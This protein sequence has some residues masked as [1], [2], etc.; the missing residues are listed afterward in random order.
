MRDAA[1]DAEMTGRQQPAS[2][3]AVVPNPLDRRAAV[4]ADAHARAEMIRQAAQ[5]ISTAGARLC[6]LLAEAHD[7]R[8]WEILDYSGFRGYLAGEFGISRAHGY[9]L[10]DQARV[11]RD[12][13][14]AAEVPPEQIALAERASRRIANQLAKISAEVR[15][16]VAGTPP[17]SRPEIVARVVSKMAVSPA[18]DTAGDGRDAERAARALIR[19]EGND[20][21]PEGSLPEQLASAIAQ[22]LSANA[23]AV[24][25]WADYLGAAST[26]LRRRSGT[27]AAARRGRRASH[28]RSLPTSSAGGASTASS[29]QLELWP[30]EL[31]DAKEGQ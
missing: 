12:L 30:G 26:A 28:Q 4:P 11:V 29:D 6:L 10:L 14:H 19:L 3:M 8:D 31:L 27:N 5:E 21:F 16:R 23:E 1:R 2:A 18:R 25:R 20:E 13:A 15:S 7:A 24:E 17:E 22:M 9:R